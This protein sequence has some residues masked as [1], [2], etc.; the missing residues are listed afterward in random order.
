MVDQCRATTSEGNPCAAKPR[1]G[2]EWCAWHDPELTDRR[3]EWSRR[4]GK[5]KSNRSRA[6]KQL[7]GEMG[8]D[9]VLRW[10]GLSI[11][12]VLSGRIEPG[13]ANAVANLAR[14]YIAV[15]EAGAVEDL[16]QRLDELE[17]MSRGRLA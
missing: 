17:R 7:P 10:V 15:R 6:A 2:R 3:Q 14:A 8:H 12:G 9:E 4:G 11:K 5:G 1:P 16:T 13:V